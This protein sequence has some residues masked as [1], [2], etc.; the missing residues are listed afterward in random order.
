VD[1]PLDVQIMDVLYNLSPRYHGNFQDSLGKFQTYET[2]TALNINLEAARRRSTSSGKNNEE[3]LALMNAI[4]GTIGNSI[5]EE[6]LVFAFS[7]SNLLDAVDT[8]TVNTLA[9][10]H[11]KEQYCRILFNSA[12]PRIHRGINPLSAIGML[13]GNPLVAAPRGLDDSIWKVG[14][15]VVALRI[16]ESAKVT[17][18]KRASRHMSW[19]YCSLYDFSNDH[20]PVLCRI[21]QHWKKL[22]C[23]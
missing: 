23:Y 7:G 13:V 8:K 22:C 18:K 6:K 11:Q 10:I 19:A 12:I 9:G 3:Q 16:V 2:S 1:E 17:M 21:P 4:R 5:P 14:G 15:C 20:F